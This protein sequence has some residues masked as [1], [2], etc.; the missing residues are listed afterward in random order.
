MRNKEKR[1]MKENEKTGNERKIKKQ[2]RNIHM[3]IKDT[4][5][6]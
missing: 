4:L 6:T 5:T 1:E 3:I 2:K